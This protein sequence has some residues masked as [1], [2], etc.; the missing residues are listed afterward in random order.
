MRYAEI[1]NN[2]GVKYKILNNWI[3]KEMSKSPRDV[4]QEGWLYLEETSEV[5]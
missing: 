4:K 5:A 3:L 1:A 2:L